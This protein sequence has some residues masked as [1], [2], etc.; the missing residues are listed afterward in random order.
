MAAINRIVIKEV[1]ATTPGVNASSSDV[2]FVP[3][4]SNGTTNRFTYKE[5]GVTPNQH[6]VGKEGDLISNDVD[7]LTWKCTKVET[8]TH[9]VTGVEG[10]IN[11]YTWEEIPYQPSYE[12]T[13]VVCDTEFAFNSY[14]GNQPYIFKADQEYPKQVSIT[15]QADV[16]GFTTDAISGLQYMYKKGEP[17][18]SYIYAKELIKSGLTVAYCA[19]E[20]RVEV[21]GVTCMVAP[22]K[23]ANDIGLTGVVGDICVNCANGVVQKYNGASWV[24]VTENTEKYFNFNVDFPVCVGVLTKNE[25]P[26]ITGAKY[27]EGDFMSSNLI[28]NNYSFKWQDG[29]WVAVEYIPLNTTYK[30]DIS[31][32]ADKTVETMYKCMSV[33]FEELKDKGEYNV[34][35]LTSGGY[36]TFEYDTNEDSKNTIVGTMISCAQ[37]RGDC[38]ALIDHTNNPIRTLNATKPNSV[39]GSLIDS[40]KIAAY[41]DYG[42][43][44]TPWGVYTGLPAT[45]TINSNVYN[46]GL[47]PASFGYLLALAKSI[48]TNANWIAI[49]GAS[50]GVVPYLASLNTIERLSNPIADSY[51]SRDAK[52]S[53]NAITNI[54]PYGLTIWGNRTLKDNEKKGNLVATSFLNLRNMLSDIKKEAY[55]VSKSLLFDQD[56]VVLWNNFKVGISPLL[57]R[58]VSG[59]GLSGYKIIRGTTKYDGSPL[60]KGEIAAVIKVFPLYAVESFE[61]TV[62]VSDDEVSVS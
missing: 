52:A 26:A 1:D 29:D 54:K 25:K 10:T 24:N 41:E 14:F 62:V 16:P 48:Q 6:T 49:A 11:I 61:I 39:Y 4:F 20:D 55:K 45:W 43:M 17:D 46:G 2:V 22:N 21:T 15:G 8:I 18:K 47:F 44:F 5:A 36:P 13:P 38:V 37:E 7:G 33:A 60:A 19:V 50:R 30:V 3:G 59:Y 34:K 42:T 35:Y 31:Y 58:M 23:D 12:N 32:A 56:S 40:H 27:K 51:Q 53:I 9:D 28:E 57:D